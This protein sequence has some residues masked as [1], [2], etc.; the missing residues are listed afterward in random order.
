MTWG[1]LC[2]APLNRFPIR[3]HLQTSALIQP[4][5]SV[6]QRVQS[7][8]PANR[9]SPSTVKFSSIT[10]SRYFL[11]RI[12]R[13]LL[14]AHTVQLS[15][16]R[17][18]WSGACHISFWC[19]MPPSFTRPP[20]WWLQP[21]AHNCVRSRSLVRRVW[22]SLDFGSDFEGS[23]FFFFSRDYHVINDLIITWSSRNIIITWSSRNIMITWL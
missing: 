11:L 9:F 8:L 23:R 22:V 13:H 2:R 21:L 4:A 1:A 6:R 14:V 10:K 17:W 3:I 5:S 18:G 16:L 12:H 15:P 20:T 19:S 7:F